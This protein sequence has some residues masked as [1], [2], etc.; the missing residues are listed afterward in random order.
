M[1]VGAIAG[2]PRLNRGPN[3]LID[4]RIVPAFV[5]LPLVRDPSDKNRIG[6][7]L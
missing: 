3:L 1:P 6:D 2:E 4:Q 7:Q 5:E